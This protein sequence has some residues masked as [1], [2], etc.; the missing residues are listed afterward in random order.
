VLAA[1]PKKPSRAQG[2]MWLWKWNAARITY[3]Q[4]VRNFDKGFR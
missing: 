4:A 2:R 1:S 3:A